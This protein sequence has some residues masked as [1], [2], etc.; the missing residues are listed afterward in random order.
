MTTIGKALDS[1]DLLIY[2]YQQDQND[3]VEGQASLVHGIMANLPDD[4]FE[5][6]KVALQTWAA[7]KEKGKAACVAI[8]IDP[9][10]HTDTLAEISGGVAAQLMLEI[11]TLPDGPDRDASLE[12]LLKAMACQMKSTAMIERYRGYLIDYGIMR[13]KVIDDELGRL[14]RNGA[15]PDGASKKKDPPTPTDDELRDRFLKGYGHLAHGLGDWRKYETGYWPVVDDQAVKSRIMSTLEAAKPEG[16]RPGSARLNS[17]SELVEVKT[18]VP[19]STWDADTDILVCSNGTLHIP[20]ATLREHAPDDYAISAVPYDYD[21]QANAEVFKWALYNT[22][23]EAADFFQEFAGYSLTTDTSLEIAV[24][25]FGPSG[26]GKS[27]I[28]TGLQAMLGDR[29]GVLGLAD[30]ERSQF[31]LYTVLGKTLM[32]AMEQPSMY[33]GC[34]HI[35]NALISGERIPVERKFKDPTEITPRCKLAWAMNELPRVSDANNGLFRRVKVIRFPLLSENDQDPQV[36]EIVKTEGAG[37]LNWALEGLA[38]LHERG[39]FDVPDCVQTATR[40]FQENNDKPLLFVTECCEAGPEYTIQSSDLYRAYKEWCHE[41]GLMAESS[42]RMAEN[43]QRL[44]FERY[45]SGGA[46]RWR[47]VQLVTKP[48]N[49]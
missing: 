22:I 20:T 28:L 2:Y 9:P 5:E 47:G 4:K 46:S 40:D 45:R 17:V 39:R 14:R 36:K 37:I 6:A 10:D 15:T 32:V 41:N 38:R 24:W 19:D 21:P 26:S 33:I 48:L 12:T 23:P 43:W 13:A 27:T 11:R 7:G 42:V 25:L 18:H 3:L 8:G 49:M 31:A 29:A 34:T 1:F 16:I 30:I 35:L 44:G